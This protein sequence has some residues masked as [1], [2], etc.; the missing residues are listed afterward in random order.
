MK[1]I[2]IIIAIFTV[3]ILTSCSVSGPLVVTD[4]KAL[5]KRGESSYTSWFG[6]PPFSGDASIQTA[7][8][9]GGITKVATV[10]RSVYGGFFRVTVTTTVTGS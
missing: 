3:V 4:N 6:F 5:E 8:K 10:D 1:K 2:K 9:N 7:A